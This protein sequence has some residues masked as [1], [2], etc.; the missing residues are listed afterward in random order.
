MSSETIRKM[1]SNISALMPVIRITFGMVP[2]VHKLLLVAAKSE[3]F[4]E[5]MWMLQFQS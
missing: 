3:N 4:C 5:K 2:F 1:Y